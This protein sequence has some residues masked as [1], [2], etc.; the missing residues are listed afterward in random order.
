MSSVGPHARRRAGRP[1]DAPPPTGARQCGSAQQ[2]V[3]FGAALGAA[4]VHDVVIGG[5]VEHMGHIP[6]GVMFNFVDQLGSP[7]PEELMARYN[8]VPQ[9]I[10]AEMIADQWEIPRSE[11]DELGLRSHQNAAKATEEG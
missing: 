2:A 11:L 9:G 10:S 4:G 5:G 3:N 1:T 8:L 7:W 6:M